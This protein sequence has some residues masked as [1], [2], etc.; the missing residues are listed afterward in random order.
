VAGDVVFGHG[1]VV[2]QVPLRDYLAFE[3]GVIPVDAGVDDRHPR[4]YA[5]GPVPCGGGFDAV[6]VPLPPLQERRIVGRVIR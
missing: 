3:V 1:V 5:Q 6:Q 2:D 4:S